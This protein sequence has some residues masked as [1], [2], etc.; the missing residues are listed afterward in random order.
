MG[1]LFCAAVTLTVCCSC[2]AQQGVSNRPD[3]TRVQNY[4]AHRAS[5]SDPKGTNMDFWPVRPGET[6]TV[7]DTD[8]PGAVTH[9][10]FAIADEESFA[11]KKVVLRMYWDGE[12]T[13]SV[14]APAGDFFGLGL[15]V[16]MPW[17]SEL[18]VVEPT[19]GLNSFFNMPYARHA[20]ITLTNEG[21]ENFRGLYFDID[22]RTYHA[23]LPDGTLHFHAQYRQAQPN[24]GAVSNWKNNQ[25]PIA[26]LRPNTDGAQNYVWMEAKGAGNY[27][28]VTM[29][30]LQNQ[31]FWWGE[32]DEMFFVD[33]EAKPSIVGTG[34]EDYF[35]GA[36]DFGGKTYTT[37]Y[38]GA[39]KVGP[40]KSGSMSSMYRFHL[41]S[42]IPFTRSFKATLEHG[43]ANVRSD[44]YYSVAYW[45]QAEPHAPFPPL[46]P[47][48]ERIP[49]R[50]AVEG[51][52]GAL[53]A[54]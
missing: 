28:G 39:I 13:P 46:P 25:D 50:I 29:S 6:V 33:G 18:L 48:A 36:G 16:C 31:D 53:P 40:E 44:N 7:L 51:P 2:V 11:L 54:P 27:V 23:P 4:T 38:A 52:G 41:E 34:A 15:G 26:D 5:S 35:I 12:R 9:I 20:R 21:S 19:C 1:R 49:R 8:G 37:P 30:V 22:Y 14:E 17:S 47:A 10:W 42:P 24:H 32:G 45:Y 3:M 43:S